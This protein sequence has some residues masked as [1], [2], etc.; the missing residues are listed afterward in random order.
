[1]STHKAMSGPFLRRP[2]ED[3]AGSGPVRIA[4]RLRMLALQIVVAGIALMILGTLSD[5]S[6]L[7]AAMRRLP[8]TAPLV[9]L[10]LVIGGGLCFLQNPLDLP[11]RNMLRL[12]AGFLALVALIP[13]TTS[14]GDWMVAAALACLSLSQLLRRKNRDLAF[15]AG[16]CVL[17]PPGVA[18]SGYLMGQTQFFGAMT[19]SAIL[20]LTGLGLAGLMRFYRHSVLVPLLADTQAGRLMRALLRV[21]LVLAVVAPVLAG[22]LAGQVHRLFPVLLALQSAA[23]LLALVYYG[24]RLAGLLERARRTEKA[25][26]HDAAHDMLTGAATR[27]AAV[28]AFLGMSGREGIGLILLD[29]D[30]FKHINDQYGH[31]AGD[32]VLR[33]LT[34]VMRAELRMDDVL[35]RWGGE[36]FLV[37]ARTR[38]EVA[39]EALAERLRAALSG[40]QPLPGRVRSVTASFGAV[41]IDPVGEPDLATAIEAADRALYLAKRLGR[42]RVVLGD[43]LAVRTEPANT[44]TV[45][46]GQR[47]AA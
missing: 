40:I 39:L 38:D 27:K 1:M 15:W 20:I 7:S 30:H 5:W 34:R 11:D 45:A 23:L 42:N 47:S 2:Q 4:M 33:E 28:D 10:A 31:P 17:L 41:L 6:G 25:L 29:I 12:W 46:S 24:G 22:M 32:H 37:L 35:A 9:D 13:V 36:E 14:G 16:A 3:S 26:L 18:V 8:D 44:L 19:V 21:W 43:P